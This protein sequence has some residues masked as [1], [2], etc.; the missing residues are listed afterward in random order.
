MLEHLVLDNGVFR[1]TQHVDHSVVR[2]CSDENDVALPVQ[3]PP[4][5]VAEASSSSITSTVCV[6]ACG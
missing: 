4:G 3:E 2:V 5:Q 6:P 1:V